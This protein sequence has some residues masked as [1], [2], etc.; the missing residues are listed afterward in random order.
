MNHN[1]DR[2]FYPL[3]SC[4]MKHNPRV[5]EETAA[6]PGFARIHPLQPD[7]QSQGALALLY[8]LERLLCAVA[9]MDAFTLQPPAGAAG[10]FTGIAMILAHHHARGE[11]RRRKVIV[12]DSAHGTNPASVAR[13]GATPVELKTGANGIID[14]AAIEAVVDDETAAL[15]L[16]VPSTLGIFERHIQKI[17]EIAHRRGAQVYLDGANMNALLGLVRPGDLGFD[18]MHI[19]LHKTCSTP[20]GGGGP[21]AGPVGVRRHLEPFLPSPRVVRE[22]GAYRW[23]AVGDASIGRTHGFHGNFGIL[24]RAYAFLRR[25]GAAGLREV[26]ETAIL[27][28]NYLQAI[29]REHF[30]LPQERPCQHEFVLSGAPLR[31]YG[32]KTTDVAKRLLDYGFY[33]PT[34]YFPLIVPEALMIEPTETETKETLDRFAAAMI[35]IAREAR[36]NPEIVRGAPH[37]TPVSRVDEARAARELDLAWEG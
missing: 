35:A 8:D 34:I 10:E 21:G 24:V 14:P 36:E 13:L 12:P 28:A 29:L 25:H 22:G 20:H 5:N 19:N 27:N 30:E 9:G 2:D 11:D 4:T 23:R 16:T 37:L 32:V 3:G 17:T 1:L 18:V 26:S 6:L 31:E 7:E 15:M 33:A